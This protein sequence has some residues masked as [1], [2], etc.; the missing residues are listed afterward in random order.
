MTCLF[1]G[2][3]KSKARLDGKVVVITG[4]N[5]GIGRE[6]AL[7]FYKRGKPWRERIY[8][9]FFSHCCY[10]RLKWRES[11]GLNCTATLQNFI[12]QL[13]RLILVWREIFLRILMKLQWRERG[14]VE[15]RSSGIC[16]FYGGTWATLA[17]FTSLWCEW[18]TDF[19]TKWEERLKYQDRKK[20]NQPP[21][22]ILEE[23]LYP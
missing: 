13:F 3:C 2:K 18:S 7:E 8:I 12:R 14:A 16:S 11:E 15:G 17:P 21:Q 6:T 19:V 1:G 23:N 5:T 10:V 4:C 22:I 9:F 20:E